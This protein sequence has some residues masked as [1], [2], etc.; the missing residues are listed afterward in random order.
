MQ[1]FVEEY[2]DLSIFSEMYKEYH[3]SS[4]LRSTIY[5]VILNMI[6]TLI[7]WN[8]VYGM[9]KNDKMNDMYFLGTS[10]NYTTGNEIIDGMIN[11]F[12]TIMVLG[13]VSFVMLAFALFDFQR[14]VKAWLT[15]SCLLIVYGVSGYTAYDFCERYIDMKT[16]VGINLVYFIVPMVSTVYGTLGIYAFFGDA[17]IKLHQFYVISNCS[18][19]AVFYLRIFPGNTAW[20]VLWTVVFWDFFAVLAPMGPLKKVQ[21]KAQDYSNN[22]LK[23]LM[24]SAEE[25]RKNAGSDQ[26]KN[27]VK[28]LIKLYSENKAMDEEFIQK[29]Q[30]RRTAIN[31]DSANSEQSPLVSPKEEEQDQRSVGSS[32]SSSVS[33]YGENTKT[34]EEF[35]KSEEVANVLEEL[36]DFDDGKEENGNEKNDLK[37]AKN[38]LES[39]INS[40]EN[41]QD[42]ENKETTMDDFVSS[43]TDV[44]MPVSDIR[45]ETERTTQVSEFPS[46]MEEVSAVEVGERMNE[47]EEEDAREIE[48]EEEESDYEE[49]YTAADALN[50]ADSVRL[51]FGDFVFYSLLI[52]QAATSGSI[53]STFAAGM[54]VVIGLIATLTILSSAENTTPALPMSVILGTFGYFYSEFLVSVY[55]RFVT[56]TN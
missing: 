15:T 52:G 40:L 10:S 33:D 29:I 3:A 39:V 45:A 25:K 2:L 54:G 37:D 9:E 42:T 12:G 11:G 1:S 26:N 18:L 31:P 28:E 53:I 22:V 56:Y 24:F 30:A 48:L 6:L 17:P 51:G 55:S 41:K 14:V 5:S 35:E 50:D 44:E 47:S 43:E 7:I 36:M 34:C 4:Q 19:I 46:E 32:S 8:G 38:I 23:L 13:V 16:E 20:F 27:R 49:E 21:E